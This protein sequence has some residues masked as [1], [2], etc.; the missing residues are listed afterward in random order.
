MCRGSLLFRNKVDA[1]A[2]QHLAISNGG[3]VGKTMAVLHRPE[4]GFDKKSRIK[5]AVCIREPSIVTLHGV[6]YALRAK[7]SFSR[8]LTAIF[9]PGDDETE[10]DDLIRTPDGIDI[11]LNEF[12]GTETSLEV[13]QIGLTPR[14]DES[15]RAAA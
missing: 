11:P 15:P 6:P 2:R 12:I 8:T 7:H 5:C 4:D 14:K 10:T 3:D 1:V 13:V 9:V